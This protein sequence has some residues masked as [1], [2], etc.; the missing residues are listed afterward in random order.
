MGRYLPGFTTFTPSFGTWYFT[1]P[2][3]LRHSHGAVLMLP[4]LNVC[5]SRNPGSL[6]ALSQHV[7][8]SRLIGEPNKTYSN[9]TRQFRG[10]S[11]PSTFPIAA[12][13]PPGDEHVQRALEALELTASDQQPPPEHCSRFSS[14]D[15]LKSGLSIVYEPNTPSPV[16]E[17][18][19]HCSDIY[20]LA[21][22]FR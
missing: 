11:N 16:I 7:G 10:R 6:S 19:A 13:M 4:S 3:L 20:I 1:P 15:I 22:V 2:P 5:F 14:K 9:L 18:V 17:Y 12:D 8:F 21:Y